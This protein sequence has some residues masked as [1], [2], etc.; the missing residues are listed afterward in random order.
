MRPNVE[1]RQPNGSISAG[2]GGFLV[3][4]ADDTDLPR[5]ARSLWVGGYGTVKITTILGDTFVWPAT[6]GYISME[7]TRVWSTGTTA[8]DIVA[9]Y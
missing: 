2:A 1:D 7:V 8:T 9:L 4:P 5:P 6:D 3:T